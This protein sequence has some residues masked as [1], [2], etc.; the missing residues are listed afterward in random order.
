MHKDTSP[1]DAASV[2]AIAK[3]LA[4]RANC[5]SAEGDLQFIWDLIGHA[6]TIRPERIRRPTTEPR[7]CNLSFP[8]PAV[9]KHSRM[10]IVD[11]PGVDSGIVAYAW[12]VVG[13]RAADPL[14]DLSAGL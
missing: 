13:K 12:K 5:E 10:L 4:R 14:A 9:Y 3:T 2:L 7:W 8:S 11:A 1:A 6:E